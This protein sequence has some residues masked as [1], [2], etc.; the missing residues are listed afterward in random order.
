MGFW[1]D[2]GGEFKNEQMQE[3]CDKM[4][5]SI[6]FGPAFSPWSNGVHERN[7]AS[8]DLTLKKMVLENDSKTV[9]SNDLVKAASWVHNTNVNW[10]GFTPLQIATG[11]AVTVPGLTTGNVATESATDSEAVRVV[12]DRMRKMTEDLEQLK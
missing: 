12:M 11:K 7:H 1:A 8:A 6:N 2:N 9:L 4:G 3:M 10:M 5:I